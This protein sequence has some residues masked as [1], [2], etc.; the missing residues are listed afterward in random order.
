MKV[1]PQ[2]TNYI[3]SFSFKNYL[4]AKS[5][6]P[7]VILSHQTL[8]NRHNTSY[9][10]LY[11]VKKSIQNDTKMLF[12]YF[13]MVV[14]G[15][16]IG[17]FSIKQIIKILSDWNRMGY[18]LLNFHIHHLLFTD[19]NKIGSLLNEFS[20]IP[21]YFFLHDFY[22]CCQSYNLTNPN[23]IFCGSHCLNKENCGNCPYYENSVS[24]IKELHDFVSC[25]LSRAEFIS[26]SE[27][28]KDIYCSFW[29]GIADKIRVIPHQ[30]FVGE[31]RGNKETLPENSPLKVGYLGAANDLKGWDV[32]KKLISQT[33]ET[34]AYE[35]Y[36]FNKNSAEESDM[37]QVPVVF[38]PQNQNAMVDAVRKAKIDIAV[39]WSKVPETYSYTCMEAFSSNAFLIT[40]EISGNIRQFVEKN[41][42]GLVLKDENDLIELFNNFVLLR[43]EVQDYK[44]SDICGPMSL[45]DNEEI[46]ELF[47]EYKTEEKTITQEYRTFR[48][49]WTYVIEFSYNHFV[50]KY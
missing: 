15:K 50:K 46:Y 10:Y 12:C 36:V 38:S 6:M 39:F 13:G 8:I 3:V 34:K 27:A 30:S 25:Y 22:L 26:P 14:D 49:P 20:D 48:N 1:Q 44:E 4:K 16:Y 37:H 24:F 35:F 41:H 33:K 2:Y 23:G 18:N 5:G 47:K 32:W 43:K 17:V 7:K 40:N 42:A 29:K 11:S 45:A 31:Y 9:V 21:I 19:R 28:T